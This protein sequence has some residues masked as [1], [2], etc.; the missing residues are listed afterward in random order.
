[1]ALLSSSTAPEIAERRPAVAVLPIGAFEQH[2]DHLPVT[3]DTIIA[4]AI[5]E[6]L[7]DAYDLLLLP[8]ITI[9]CSHE[10]ATF[11]GTVSISHETLGRIVA[12]IRA[13]LS[14]AGILRLIMVNAHGGNYVLSN[15]AQEANIERPLV[16][17]FPGRDDWVRARADGNLATNNSEDMHAG[18]LETSIMLHLAPEL[19]R[20]SH[21][22]A[23]HEQPSRP[24]LLTLGMKEYT[25]TGVI[26]RPSEA[27][28]T[29][30]KAVLE[31]LTRSAAALVR[32]L[33]Q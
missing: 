6:A 21:K 22:S 12:D 9:S 20:D 24:N 19:V 26:G 27:T 8:P 14:S 30:G 5:A 28:A 31:S 15:I 32:L 1:M 18:E 23:D 16:G 13:S 25:S 29:K 2:G 33:G 10:H 3:T 17:L 4:C 11:A 7:A